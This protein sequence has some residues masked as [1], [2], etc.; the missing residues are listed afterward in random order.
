MWVG[1]ALEVKGVVLTDDPIIVYS[2]RWCGDCRRAKRVLD[3]H[4]A[5]YKWIDIEEAPDALD[6][7]MAINGGKQSVPTILFPD[8]TV[9]VEPSNKELSVLLQEKA[10]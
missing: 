9:T 5:D 1:T 6:A 3:E 8:G 4:G 7:M 10:A 2:T